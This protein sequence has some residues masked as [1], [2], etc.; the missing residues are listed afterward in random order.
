MT[1]NELERLAVRFRSNCP[2]LGSADTLEAISEAGLA[3]AYGLWRGTPER[4][5]KKREAMRH[6]IAQ[7][8]D[9]KAGRT[10]LK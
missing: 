4:Y 7:Q 3:Y 1:K 8:L 6:S 5:R 9:W 2:N 10:G